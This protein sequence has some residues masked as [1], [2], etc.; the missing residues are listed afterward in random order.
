VLYNSLHDNRARRSSKLDSRYK[1][2]YEVLRQVKD[3]VEERHLAL[4]FI[5][6]LLVERLKI[7][8]GSKDDAFK[9]AMEDANQFLVDC[10]TAWKG[11]PA[12]RTE[13]EL[14]SC[15]QRWRRGLETLRSGFSYNSP[16]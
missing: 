3:E 4:G 9:L 13:M 14:T 10:I 2:P 1:G 12:L 6:L 11:N 8:V 15:F 7:F 16:V 5:K